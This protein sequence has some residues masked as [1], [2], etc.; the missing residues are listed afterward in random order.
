LLGSGVVR[1]T[2]RDIEGMATI[3]E[4][5]GIGPKYARMLRKS[6]V[7]TTEGL[8]KRGNTRKG[9]SEL[10]ES[11][12]F[13][14]E[15]ILEWV[16]RADLMRVRGIGSEYADLLENSGV[17]TVKELRRR[18]VKTLTAKM[19]E[20]NEKKKLVRRLPTESMVAAWIEHAS[21]LEPIV[22]Y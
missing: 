15:Q 3:E 17:D 9:R 14:P 11:A 8:L 20:V 22:K 13:S 16:N 7:R 1:G 19:N 6:G 21:S 4:I 5:E 18:N 2:E 12:G 10:A